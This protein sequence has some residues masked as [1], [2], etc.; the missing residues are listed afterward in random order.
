MPATKFR[1]DGKSEFIQTTQFL[2]LAPFSRLTFFTPEAVR[3]LAQRMVTQL[4]MPL[5]T[6][7]PIHDLRVQ[8]NQGQYHAEPF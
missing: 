8:L 6:K 1:Q 2:W 5:D 3:V 4:A 7:I